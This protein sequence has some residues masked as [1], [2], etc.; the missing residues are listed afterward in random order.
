MPGNDYI[1]WKSSINNIDVFDSSE[2]RASAAVTYSDGFDRKGNFYKEEKG[3]IHFYKGNKVIVSTES[4]TFRTGSETTWKPQ[5][6]CQTSDENY[7]HQDEDI[8]L[9]SNEL[10]DSDNTFVP[11]PSKKRRQSRSSTR[12]STKPK[13]ESV[14][15]QQQLADMNSNAVAS[16]FVNR[17]EYKHLRISMSMMQ[18]QLFALQDKVSSIQ[19][20]QEQKTINSSLLRAKKFIKYELFRHIRRAPARFRG[21]CT[22]PFFTVVKRAPIQ[23]SIH[24]TLQEFAEIANDI[25][26]RKISKVLFLPSLFTIN[27][28]SQP[29]VQKHICFESFRY[30]LSWLDVIDSDVANSLLIRNTVRKSIKNIQVIGGAQWSENDTNK[31]LNVFLGY[32]CIREAPKVKQCPEIVSVDVEEAKSPVMMKDVSRAKHPEHDRSNKESQ[33]KTCPEIVEVHNQEELIQQDTNTASREIETITLDDIE[34]DS[35]KNESNSTVERNG[36]EFIASHAVNM[37]DSETDAQ[38]MNRSSIH[39]NS[40][41][42]DSD[43]GCFHNQFDASSGN[44][45]IDILSASTIY[46]FDSF[47]FSWRPLPGL[48]YQ[49][50]SE[51]ESTVVLGKMVVHIPAVIFSGAPTCSRIN[52]LLRED[53]SDIL[54]SHDGN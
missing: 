10:E 44:Q 45:H 46:D 13:N 30:L 20:A 43:N 17:T 16:D 8:N 4:D 50:I 47:T 7:L 14:H 52:F 25:N 27:I 35:N 15:Q 23:F 21:E 38:S 9:D 32:S 37:E 2:I 40:T 1:W 28:K 41:H 5:H 19:A 48:R 51:L 18:R 22:T 34:S 33:V 42:W 54:F 31:P 3:T 29:L 11:R 49:D 39:M 53:Q 6:G 24:C 26:D 36:I 12:P